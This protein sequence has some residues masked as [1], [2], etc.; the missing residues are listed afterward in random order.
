MCLLINEYARSSEGA[1]IS[2]A[3]RCDAMS[4]GDGPKLI[5]V[6]RY[7]CCM[8]AVRIYQ[9]FTL[10]VLSYQFSSAHFRG[11]L[12]CARVCTEIIFERFSWLR[13]EVRL[14][15]DRAVVQNVAIQFF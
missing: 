12:Q 4:S 13:F 15:T 2:G 6:H 8:Y 5:P 7:T 10:R 14:R 11:L 9:R 3:S 1:P